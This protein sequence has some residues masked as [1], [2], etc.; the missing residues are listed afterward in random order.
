VTE[1]TAYAQ[2]SPEVATTDFDRIRDAFRQLEVAN[3][4]PSHVVL[5]PRDWCN[6]ELAKVNAGTDD[7][8]ILGTPRGT[9][10]APLWGRSVILSNALTPG[11][12][13]VGD[14]QQAM[15]FEKSGVSFAAAYQDA[16]NFRQNLVTLRA[17]ARL[18]LAVW[19]QEG[20]VT[21]N[22]A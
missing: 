1:A 2:Q 8:Y 20:F 13:L 9:S 21:G 18:A 3:Y 16:S 15:V 17:E 19:R 11:T 10:S 12:F 22:F 7:R 5:N 4:R 6:L 14:F